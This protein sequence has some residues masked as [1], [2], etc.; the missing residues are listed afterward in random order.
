MFKVQLEP[1]GRL[2]GHFFQCAGLFKQM[3]CIGNDAELL[4]AGQLR[5]GLAVEREDLLI[6]AADQ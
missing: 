3:R 2:T 5:I 4:G 6:P 1:D